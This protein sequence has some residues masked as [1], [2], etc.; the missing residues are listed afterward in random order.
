MNNF[1]ET[2]KMS[3][4][5]II[6][7]NFIA[8]S[9]CLICGVNVLSRSLERMNI[10]AV[11]KGLD[12]FTGSL[13]MAL[14]T[15]T[16]ITALLQS[17]TAVTLITVGLVNSGCMSLM[18]AVGII[19]GANIGTTITAQLMTFNLYGASW[20]I[21]AA[22]LLMRIIFRKKDIKN[23]GSIIMGF[24]LMFAGLGILNSGIPY[25]KESRALYA[26]L[27]TYGNKPLAGLLAGL[28]AT[29]LVHSSSATVGITMVL[30]NNGIIGFEGAVGLILGDN[31][32]T[33]ATAQVGSIGAGINA[34][35]TAWAHTIYNIAGSAIA[36][37]FMPSFC[38]LVRFLTNIIGQGEAHLVPN[39]H[40]L[41]NILSAAL[42][43]P[44]TRY[45]VRFIKS[46]VR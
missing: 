39:A 37:A 17:S 43:Y 2:V 45:Y 21:M 44:F 36:F 28:V 9:L 42:F 35:R 40:T 3:L 24:G 12:M 13:P 34:R 23:I 41:F 1:L 26:F 11:K 31:I 33:C 16:A 8:G 29:M 14:L 22:G 15:G 32:G 10:R 6:A 18:Q 19:Y 27:H 7:F 46:I 20:L 4:T 5:L 38:S 30:F 25:L